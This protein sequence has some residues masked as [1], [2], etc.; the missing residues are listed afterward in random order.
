MNPC[1]EH[2]VE[3][4][5]I[6]QVVQGSCGGHTEDQSEITDEIGLVRTTGH[7]YRQI[8]TLWQAVSGQ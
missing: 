1:L 7:D 5:P 6:V 8:L 3:V 4:W 2:Q